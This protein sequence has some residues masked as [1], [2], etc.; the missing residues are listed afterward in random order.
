MFLQAEPYLTMS[1]FVAVEKNIK[2]MNDKYV[3]LERKFNQLMKYF[4]EIRKAETPQDKF[5]QE[6]MKNI[7]N[8][9]SGN[10]MRLIPFLKSMK[11]IDENGNPL[12]LYR[13]FRS[14]SDYP[15]KSLGIG[16]R[17]AYAAMFSRDKDVYKADEAQI[18]GHVMAITGKEETAAIVR[19]A[20]QTF[21]AVAKLSNFESNLSE[22]NEIGKI[23]GESPPVDK[24]NIG[25][26]MPL[27]HT[28]VLNLPTTTTKEVY[29]VIFTSLKENLLV[30]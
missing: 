12:Q 11:F 22:S 25:F 6:F 10:D 19:L 23:Q 7:L 28:I 3:N 4:E 1:D 29:D 5:S 8:F 13:E 30:K 21:L 18:K 27:T 20:T 24:P 9:K 17:N 15:S 26:Q 14:E 16:L 2:D